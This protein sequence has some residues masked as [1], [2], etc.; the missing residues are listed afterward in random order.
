MD[1]YSIL[2]NGEPTFTSTNGSSV[3]DLCL[4]YGPMVSQNEHNLTTDENVEI[5][6]RAPNRS[7]VPVLFDLQCSLEKLKQES[8]GWRKQIGSFR[9]ILLRL[10]LVKS[11]RMTT[12][13]LH[14][15]IFFEP[16]TGEIHTLKTIN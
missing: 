16:S 4:I 1:T 15:G 5:F 12:T 2:N 3:I 11:I 9:Q 8:C 6:T 14:S 13:P 7:H 10:V